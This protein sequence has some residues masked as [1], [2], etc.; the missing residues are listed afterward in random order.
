M[1]LAW[2]TR[3]L[4]DAKRHPGKALQDVAV[5]RSLRGRAESLPHPIPRSAPR[6]RPI[7]GTLAT[8]G[9]PLH[10]GSG[11]RM[12]KKAGGGGDTFGPF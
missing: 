2:R 7:A 8:Y 9:P 6:A 3:P 4:D 1:H 10:T 5:G 11:V 12:K